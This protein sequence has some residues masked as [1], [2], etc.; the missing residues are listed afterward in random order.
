MCALVGVPIKWLCEVH[1]ATIQINN[2]VLY[3][4]CYYS[5][6]PQMT[7]ALTV[8]VLRSLNLVQYGCVP[9]I[10]FMSHWKQ[11]AMVQPHSRHRHFVLVITTRPFYRNIVTVTAPLRY[12]GSEM[13]H[14]L[15]V[16]K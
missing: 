3:R 4:W 16:Y 7:V 15:C 13:C 14:P 1:G 5:V 8:A 9:M 6:R 10:V 2:L 12:A 11:V